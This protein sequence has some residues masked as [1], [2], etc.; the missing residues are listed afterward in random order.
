V[1]RLPAAL[2]FPTHQRSV[3][4]WAATV[5]AVGDLEPGNAVGASR[6]HPL[7]PPGTK[8]GAERVRLGFGEKLGGKH[9]GILVVEPSRKH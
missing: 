5:A 6:P 3:A 2:Q 7:V 4:G 9:G 1:V 8:R